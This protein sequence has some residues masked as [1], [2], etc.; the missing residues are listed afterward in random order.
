[1][2]KRKS[3]TLIEVIVAISIVA[4]LT[5]TI[6]PNITGLQSKPKQA[7]L[8]AD[9]ESYK[10]AIT[11]VN[12]NGEDIEEININKYLDTRLQFTSGVSKGKNQYGFSYVFKELSTS[13]V[14]SEVVIE[15]SEMTT[16]GTKKDVSLGAK[17]VSNSV[18]FTL[19]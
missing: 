3:Y 7:G 4:M 11:E 18:K 12:L 17:R 14:V 10:L 15:T 5:T 1:M 13:E 9:I 19:E 6:V 8:Q 16:G 2:G